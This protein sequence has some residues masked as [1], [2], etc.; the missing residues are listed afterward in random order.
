M[1]GLFKTLP[2]ALV[3]VLAV[4]ACKSSE[5]KAEEFYQSGLALSES[6]DY[7]RAIVE[8]RNVFELNGSHRDARFLLANS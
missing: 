1:T 8:L 4:S 6:G 5:E 3:L 2:L 7:D